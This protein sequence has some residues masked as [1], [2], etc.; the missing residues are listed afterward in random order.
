MDTIKIGSCSQYSER[1]YFDI[2]EQRCKK[3]Y[4]SGCSGN[5]NNFES[6]EECRSTCI[7]AIGESTESK[8]ITLEIN[9]ERIFKE[10]F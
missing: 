10:A 9:I 8:N 5:Q 4:Y 2:I 6:L 7:V 3:F 1:Y